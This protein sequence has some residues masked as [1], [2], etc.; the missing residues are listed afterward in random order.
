MALG[1]LRDFV[2]A[3]SGIAVF[4]GIEERAASAVFFIEVED[5]IE[6][7]VTESGFVECIEN[8]SAER[9]VL[10][11]DFEPVHFLSK[12]FKGRSGSVN[13]VVARVGFG[14][15]TELFPLREDFAA[16]RVFRSG[17][18]IGGSEEFSAEIFPG[19]RGGV[20]FDDE[21]V[22]RACERFRL[23]KPSE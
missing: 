7:P 16:N 3:G 1:E 8:N 19:E 5:G 14:T 23:E 9:I 2:G 11:I 6:N 20:P 22:D 10:R 21:V 15:E 4:E 18:R 13:A 12:T 17:R